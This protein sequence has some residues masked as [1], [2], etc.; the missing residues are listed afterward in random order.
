EAVPQNTS[1]K[2]SDGLLINGSV[3]NGASS[4]FAQSAAFGNNRRG[5]ASLYNGGLGFVLDNS[6]LDARSYSYTGQ[7]TPKPGYNHIQGIANFGGPIR[8]PH[9]L[10]NGPNLF[11]LYQWTRARNA[12]V[13]S[14][15]VPTEAERNGDLSALPQLYNPGGTPIPGNLVT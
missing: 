5:L 7:N 8:I 13:S 10:R 14:G 1:E 11:V 15:L 12:S 6:A 4:A 9:L 2:A 3:N